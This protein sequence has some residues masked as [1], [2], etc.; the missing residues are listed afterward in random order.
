MPNPTLLNPHAVLRRARPTWAFAIVGAVLTAGCLLPVH[1]TR[2]VE[3]TITSDGIT[4][5]VR[6]TPD[7]STGNG[8]WAANLDVPPEGASLIVTID[9]MLPRG[10]HGAAFVAVLD[11]GRIVA[12]GDLFH[13]I[14]VRQFGEEPPASG[15]SEPFAFEAVYDLKP[16]SPTVIVAWMGVTGNSTVWVAVPPTVGF[17][18][19]G[20]SR[21]AIGFEPSRMNQS[22]GPIPRTGM[23]DHR[24]T[25]S[26][27]FWSDF[28][29]GRLESGDLTV[30]IDGKSETKHVSPGPVPTVTSYAGIWKATDFNLSYQVVGADPESGLYGALFSLP[31]AVPTAGLSEAVQAACE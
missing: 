16:G 12:E 17:T 18:D 25:G 9:T 30:A 23:L 31:A 3:H 4:Y 24:L 19:L 10:P 5:D 14:E 1:T 22:T 15:P 29:V 21:G 6:A 13:C 28:A 7:L 11:G 8:A 26:T 2:E 20:Q 27:L